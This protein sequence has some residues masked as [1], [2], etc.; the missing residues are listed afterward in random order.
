MPIWMARFGKRATT[1]EPD[2]APTTAAAIISTSVSGIDAHGG[3]EYECL[4]D[5]RQ[6]MTGIQRAGN[7][8]VGHEP[9]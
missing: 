6:R 2:H 3:D 7:T 1:P 9:Q 5:G 4:R 8:F